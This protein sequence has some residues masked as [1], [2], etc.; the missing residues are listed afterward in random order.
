M[1]PSAEPDRYVAGV[2]E[3][4]VVAI[5][6]MPD[7]VAA[8]GVSMAISAGGAVTAVKTTPLLTIDEGM[9]ALRKASTSGYRPPSDDFWKR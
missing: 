3:T 5:F 1:K 4:D 7:D 6:Q 2:R 9:A 8:A